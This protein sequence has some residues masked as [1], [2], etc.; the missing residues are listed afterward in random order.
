[1]RLKQYL[2][3]FTLRGVKELKVF[4]Q[5]GLMSKEKKQYEKARKYYNASLQI[6]PNSDVVNYNCAVLFIE[7]KEYHL[8]IAHL[9]RAMLHHSEFKEGQNLLDRVKEFIAS[10][11]TG[12]ELTIDQID[13]AK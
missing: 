8:A 5:F 13:P 4:N 3:K 2:K 9:K 1:M 6:S 11:N 7:M 12:H 10:G